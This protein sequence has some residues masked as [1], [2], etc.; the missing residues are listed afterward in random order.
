VISASIALARGGFRLDVRLE[1]SARRVALFG[2][3]G[4]G[5]TTVLDA[6]AGLVRPEAGRIEVGGRTLFDAAAAVDLPPRERGVG[7]VRQAPDLFPAMTAGQ[8]VD[9][10][11]SCRGG[12]ASSRPEAA[13]RI[14]GLL[15]RRPHELSAGETRRVQIAR[16]LASGPAL[17]LLDEPFSNLD[18][19]ARREILP[20]LASL[21]GA[22]AVPAILVTHD[23]GEVFSFAEEV[24]VVEN[25]RVVAQGEPLATLSRPGSWPV[26]RVSGVENFLAVKI[27]GPDARDGGTIADWSGAPLHCPALSGAAGERATLALFA[28]DVLIARGPVERLSAR[29]VFPMRVEEV[30]AQGDDVLVTLAAASRRLR[31]RITR[32]ARTALSIEPGADVTAVFKSSALRPVDSGTPGSGL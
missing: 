11:R 12:A 16:A 26:A 7:Y 2:A 29:N 21:P 20:M 1:T 32:G 9:F 24:V 4:A 31:S 19:P 28:E 8:N 25:G 30:S 5:K 23:V 22:F 17:L 18:A 14:G 13:L 10:A 3:S 27:E 6:I 15:R